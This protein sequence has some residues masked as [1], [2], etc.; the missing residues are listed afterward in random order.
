MRIVQVWP[1]LEPGDTGKAALEF[2]QELTRQGVKPVVI[3][4]GGALVAR[5]ELHGIQHTQLPLN[6]RPILAIAMV[7]RLRNA[8]QGLN[9]DVIHV[10]GRLAAQLVW[11]AWRGM[12]E[13]ARPSLVT[14]V[15]Q[16]Y[17]P[18]RRDAGLT[19][20]HSV[21][22]S[23][24]GIADHLREHYGEKL[25]E[26]VAV[27]HQGIS[28]RE[29]DRSKPIPSQWHLRL[30]NSYPQL[31]GKNWWLYSGSLSEEGEL[32]VFLQAL[33]HAVN[34]SE[35]LFGLVVGALREDDLRYV[36]KLEQQARELGL[37]GRVLFLGDRK[38]LRE[39]YASSQLTFCLDG[40]KEP[41]G[42]SAIQALA[43]GCPV[44]AYRDSC[45]GEILARC[46][47]EGMVER[48][49]PSTLSEVGLALMARGAKAELYGFFYEDAVKQTVS[50]YRSLRD[51]SLMGEA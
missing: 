21:I 37:E 45:A 44:L 31:E 26:P 40:A 22:V 47:P 4:A 32:D 5:L 25:A 35:N 15:D 27:V 2:I 36:R 38:D 28:S 16:Y 34:R 18:N 50:F 42:K 7:R 33:A 8:L 24:Q 29:F 43:M 30:L 23:S 1:E 19:G 11:R 9:A 41:S 20:G 6:K 49:S 39:L 3:S 13:S 48:E 10:H 14:H 46:F 51:F 12:E 17:L